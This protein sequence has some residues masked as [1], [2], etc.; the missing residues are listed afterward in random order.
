MD[1]ESALLTLQSGNVSSLGSPT[2]A[3][4]DIPIR[5]ILGDM[6]DKYKKFKLVLNSHGG[7]FL[8][9]IS[10]N[11]Q[12]FVRI[13]GLD[14]INTTEYSIINNYPR[15]AIFLLPTITT[16]VVNVNQ[17]PA[18]YGY[19]FMKPSNGKVD[20]TCVILDRNMTVPTFNIGVNMFVF[21]IYG[22]D[23]DE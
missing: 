10:T 6:W 23:D 22:I 12:F 8:N 18:N 20:L 13:S 16:S 7:Y 19:T 2:L 1:K 17:L 14:F 21:S 11:T 5:D 15:T 4:T 9:G 3:F